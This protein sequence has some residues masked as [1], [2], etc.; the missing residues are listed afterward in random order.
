MQARVEQGHQLAGE[1][2][3][4]ELP[5]LGVK[6]DRVNLMNPINLNQTN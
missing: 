1:I 6:A 3:Q 4:A 5:T 2:R